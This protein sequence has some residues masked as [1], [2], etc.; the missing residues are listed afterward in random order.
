MHLVFFYFFTKRCFSL[1]QIVHTRSGLAHPALYIKG[2]GDYYLGDN[3]SGP[4]CDLLPPPRPGV[5]NVWSH[6]STSLCV[7]GVHTNNFT[8]A[9]HTFMGYFA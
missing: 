3:S 6:T 9:I 2:N 5:T 1:F 8:S 7:Y 4:E